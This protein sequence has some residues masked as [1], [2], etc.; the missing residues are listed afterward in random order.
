MIFISNFDR[1]NNVSQSDSDAT[2]LCLNSIILYL[3]LKHN[4][5][6]VVGKSQRT[7]LFFHSNGKTLSK[8]TLWL[9]ADSFLHLR[10]N[11]VQTQNK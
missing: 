1:L 2:S 7:S 11:K 9:T 3:L 5:D 4:F 8:K 6:F 10:T